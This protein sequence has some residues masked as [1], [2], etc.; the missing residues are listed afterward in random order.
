M[1]FGALIINYTPKEQ[2]ELFRKSKERLKSE[3]KSDQASY[4][5]D[6]FVLRLSFDSDWDEAENLLLKAA[7]EVTAD[8]IKA[9]STEPYIR[10]DMPDWYGAY[11]RL[12]FMT[13]ATDRPKIIHEISKRV[14]K[15][16]QSS[17]KVDLAIPYIYSFKKGYQWAPPYSLENL[18]T[19]R[20]ATK[21][22]LK[23]LVLCPKCEAKNF[24]DAR[25]C[26]ECSERLIKD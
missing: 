8:I 24:S 13:L 7:K 21:G 22:I 10:A 4:M 6:E 2:A 3:S 14:F 18:E 5:L 16:I 17:K 26:N 9:T 23:G 19:I 1:L 25:Y 15:G 20:D 11:L 12:R